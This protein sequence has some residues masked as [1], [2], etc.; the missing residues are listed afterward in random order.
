MQSNKTQ[1]RRWERENTLPRKRAR[2]SC[3]ACKARKTKCVGVENGDCEYCKSLNVPCEFNLKNRKRPFYRVSEEAYDYLIKLL[4]RFVSE[5]ELPELTVASISGY[6]EQMNNEPEHVL[7]EDR[8]RNADP[9]DIVSIPNPRG[10]PQ[11]LTVPNDNSIFQEELGCMTLDSSGKYRYVGANSSLRWYHAARMVSERAVPSDPRVVI[12]LK[13]GLLPPTTPESVASQHRVEHYLPCHRLSMEYTARFFAQAHSMHCFYSLEQF[14]TMLDHTLENQGKTSS[15]SWLCSLYSIF[16]IGSIRPKGTPTTPDKTLPEDITTPAG[17]LA[18]AKE[19]V[20]RAA[21]DA[22]IES[23]R[24]FALLSLAMHSN[25]YS[26]EAYLYLGTAARIGFSL[27]LHRDIFPKDLSTV[28]RERYRRVWWTVYIL[29]HEMANRY[30]YPCAISD[31]LGFMTTGPASERILDPSPNMPQGFQTLSVSLVQLQKKINLEC[32]LEPCHG[33]GRLP[34][35]LVTQSLTTLKKWLEKVPHH[36]RWDCAAPPQHLRSI[37][38]LHLRYWS[39][40]ISIS[41]PF[42]LLSVTKAGEIDSL[43]RLRCYDKLS[44]ACIEAAEMSVRILQRMQDMNILSSLTLNDCHCAGEAMCVLL[45]ALRKAQSAK[46]QDMLRTCLGTLASMEKVG[47]CERIVPDIQARV[48][49]SG[50]LDLEAPTGIQEQNLLSDGP[51]SS[52]YTE[53]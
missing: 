24:A 25:C 19:L 40:V 39:L 11:E 29:D 33:G 43:I 41:R 27:G 21:E 49:E 1:K 17:Y 16:A 53:L 18:L 13:T 6:L 52:E 46:H 50:V 35:N 12:P 15:S 22:D 44:N 32:F 2:Q 10:D 4:R 26:L 47:W 31:D 37:A 9:S 42:L 23:V 14:Y 7:S 45:L 28:D 30:G 48:Y 3:E 38:V 20:P 8:D 51:G 5:E 34:I 36:L